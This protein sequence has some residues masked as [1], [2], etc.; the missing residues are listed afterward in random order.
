[1]HFIAKSHCLHQ[2]NIGAVEQR[3]GFL[4]KYDINFKSADGMENVVGLNFSE[5]FLF[6]SWRGRG[7]FFDHEELLLF[8]KKISQS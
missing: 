6:F 8:L 7:A 2:K 3:V 5:I 1:M 4:I